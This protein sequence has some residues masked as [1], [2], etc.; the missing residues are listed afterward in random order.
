MLIGYPLI[1]L[2]IISLLINRKQ[3]RDIVHYA[4]A[5]IIPLVTFIALAV[6]QDLH[7]QMALRKKL[8]DYL[9]PIKYIATQAGGVAG[10]QTTGF[11]EYYKKESPHFFDRCFDPYIN[12]R[13]FP[14]I[15]ALIYYFHV[16]YRVR[17]YSFPSLMAQGACLSTFIMHIIAWDSFRISSY[18]VMGAM[19][20]LWIL[21]ET[22]EGQ[23]T[24]D[25]L[26][27]L[28]IPALLVNIFSKT[29]LMDG[30]IDKFTSV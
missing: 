12:M 1:F 15:M 8:V 6:F 27:L 20:I 18:S 5:L 29:P 22:R 17:P 10:T 23:D 11:L 25:N 9:I 13:I 21:S 30:K 24:V 28:A 19:I 7:D 4:P 26:S 3:W 2:A 16:R 14:A